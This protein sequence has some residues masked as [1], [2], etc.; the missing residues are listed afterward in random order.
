[1]TAIP[2]LLGQPMP[3]TQ[4]IPQLPEMTWNVP[5]VSWASA[6]SSRSTGTTNF[7]RIVP[8]KG[9]RTDMMPPGSRRRRVRAG[10]GG[11]SGVSP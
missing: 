10:G 8:P 6:A 1:M 4:V 5:R 9:D 7:F 11:A 2:V 3:S